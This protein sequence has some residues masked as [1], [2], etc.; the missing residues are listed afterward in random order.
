MLNDITILKCEVMS[1]LVRLQGKFTAQCAHIAQ[2]LFL[3]GAYCAVRGE[4]APKELLTD[5]VWETAILNL[6]HVLLDA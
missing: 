6:F 3:A 2:Y 1:H 5:L 4:W